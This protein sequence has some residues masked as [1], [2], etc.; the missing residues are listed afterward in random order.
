[1]GGILDRVRVVRGAA[2]G[3]LLRVQAAGSAFGDG[4]V[5]LSRNRSQH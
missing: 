3:D 2:R 4:G 5:A 1:V